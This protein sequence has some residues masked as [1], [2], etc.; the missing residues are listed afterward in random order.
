ML[1]SRG[2][3]RGTRLDHMYMNKIHFEDG[4]R[5]RPAAA[6]DDISTSRVKDSK[7]SDRGNKIIPRFGS[8]SEHFLIPTGSW[9]FK[10]IMFYYYFDSISMPT[11]AHVMH[12]HVSY[13]YTVSGTFGCSEGW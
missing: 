11:F 4:R 10:I 8:D 3:R 9:L 5:R 7:I 12:G 2:G 1:A 13:K 6:S